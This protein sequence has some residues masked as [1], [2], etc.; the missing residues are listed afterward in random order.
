VFVNEIDASGY[1][2]RLPPEDVNRHLNRASVGLCLSAEEGAM[3][4][5]AEYLLAGLPVI[6]TPNRGGRDFYID[7]DYCITVA[8]DPR[9]IAAAVTALKAREIPRHAIRER[10]M[11]RIQSER[12]RFIE[13]VNAIYAELGVGEEFAGFWPLKRPVIMEWLGPGTARKR[14]TEGEVDEVVLPGTAAGS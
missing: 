5:C 10:T 12:A 6:T 11:R 8:D 4:A 2:V 14:A 9:E 1:P 7:E 13:L 3:F